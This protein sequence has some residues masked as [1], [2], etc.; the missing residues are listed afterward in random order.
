MIERII[1]LPSWLDYISLLEFLLH[2]ITH[3]STKP[4]TIQDVISFERKI[5][6]RLTRCRRRVRP[7][8]NNRKGEKN[9]TMATVPWGGLGHWDQIAHSLCCL[10]LPRMIQG[11]VVQMFNH[12][13]MPTQCCGFP[14]ECP[15]TFLC[16]II[17]RRMM[18]S[19]YPDNWKSAGKSKVALYVRPLLVVIPWSVG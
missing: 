12:I 4:T 10:P 2:H 5:G 19:V 11:S 7:K 15:L 16:G 17:K 9:F 3:S 6:R 1:L 14:K 8:P 13:V 18:H